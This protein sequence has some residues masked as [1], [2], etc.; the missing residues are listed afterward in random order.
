MS[1]NGVEKPD[2]CCKS[3]ESLKINLGTK[4]RGTYEISSIFANGDYSFD[5]T[6]L[7]SNP[8]ESGLKISNIKMDDVKVFKNRNTTECDNYG[9]IN[10]LCPF[11]TSFD[12]CTK[13]NPCSLNPE[14]E[15]IVSADLGTIPCRI[16]GKSLRYL[17]FD[18]NATY[19]QNVSHKKTL[20]VAASYEDID[21][22]ESN[23]NL[24]RDV[25]ETEAPSDGPV[26]LLISFGGP[27]YLG[28]RSDNKIKMYV[29]IENKGSGKLRQLD[30]IVI[31]PIGE[32]PDWLNLTES[33]RCER[34]GNGIE[35]KK[36]GE[37]FFK[38]SKPIKY[39]CDLQILVDKYPRYTEGTPAI[40][41][42]VKFQGVLRYEYMETKSSEA[43]RI[44]RTDC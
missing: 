35:L 37:G 28:K 26:D 29:W 42:T 2:Y 39:A 32:F 25:Y 16:D 36:F 11:K 27:Y 17:T 5:V 31:E 6:I 12:V 15:K 7:N 21:I 18:V 14:E 20:G 44:D 24:R 33:N 41:Q 43:Q 10:N 19:E 13:N 34:D 1:V 3:Y 9:S 40:Y 38:L 4:I 23:V 22:F 30:K 8:R